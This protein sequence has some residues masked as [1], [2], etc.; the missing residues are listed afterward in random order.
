MIFLNPHS[1]TYFTDFTETEKGE[2]RERQR[3]INWLPLSPHPAL[4]ESNPEP[5][6]VPQL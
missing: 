6:D 2:D 3:N 1:R 5:R 4:G